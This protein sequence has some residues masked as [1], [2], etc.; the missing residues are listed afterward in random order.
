MY[1]STNRVII[2]VMYAALLRVNELMTFK[3]VSL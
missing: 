2:L 3:A 1:P